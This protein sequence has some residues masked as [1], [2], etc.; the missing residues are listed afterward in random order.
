MKLSFMSLIDI[1]KLQIDVKT[2]SERRVD[3]KYCNLLSCSVRS[4]D[5]NVQSTY[6]EYVVSTVT[7][8]IDS[9]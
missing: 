7:F 8:L 3:V 5:T 2:H 9:D 1:E 6:T 4:Q